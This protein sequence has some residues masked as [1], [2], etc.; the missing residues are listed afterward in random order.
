[1]QQLSGAHP[2]LN[3]QSSMV[4]WSG[5]YTSILRTSMCPRHSRWFMCDTT[6]VH[7]TT[8][9]LR[10]AWLFVST[11]FRS[12]PRH[13]PPDQESD[14]QENQD[15]SGGSTDADA[16]LG[17]LLQRGLV[18]LGKLV[19]HRIC[20]IDDSRSRLLR[21]NWCSRSREGRWCD[22][23]T[24]GAAPTTSTIT[25]CHGIHICERIRHWW[26]HKRLIEGGIARCLTAKLCT[27]EPI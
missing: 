20:D 27:P 14:H 18:F 26:W 24:D 23:A 22:T 5:R 16:D 7:L 11:N 19:L 10:S 25:A 12:L 13:A 6:H 1:M 3:P 2:R 4:N 8:E 15:P 17:S 21:V 9:P